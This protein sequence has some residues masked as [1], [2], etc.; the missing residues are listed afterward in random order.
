MNNRISKIGRAALTGLLFLTACVSLNAQERRNISADQ[1][2]LYVISAKAGAVNYVSGAVRV[3]RESSNKQHILAKTDELNSGDKVTTDASGKAEILLNPGSFLRLAENTQFEF[4]DTSLESL[5]LNLK[6]G[7]AL[8]EATAIGG[9]GSNIAVIT[10]HTRI[11]LD[12]S[13]VYRINVGTGTTEVFVWKGVATV[14]REMVKGGRKAVFQNGMTTVAK[15]DK[16]EKD[17]LDI[18]SKDRAKDLAKLNDKLRNRELTSAFS[19]YNSGFGRRMGYGFWVFDRF[20]RSYCFVPYGWDSWG[21][22]YGYG[23]SRNIYFGIR[24]IIIRPTQT[25]TTAEPNFP[26]RNPFPS[27]RQVPV[28]PTP[29]S[30]APIE[31]NPLPAGRQVP[32]KTIDR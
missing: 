32:S 13:G 22:P 19:A 20:T 15:F 26:T 14:G 21:S 8:I 29:P 7:S 11:N 9:G 16:D 2:R 6:Q 1:E 25:T 4:T 17:A 28:S 3:E 30:S 27:G 24:P 10:P 18:W 31:R 23:Y 5:K 12:K